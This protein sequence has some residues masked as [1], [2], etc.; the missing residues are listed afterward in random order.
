MQAAELHLLA[1]NLQPT[2]GPL[3][4]PAEQQQAAGHL[5]IGAGQRHTLACRGLTSSDLPASPACLLSCTSS[6]SSGSP[7]STAAAYLLVL[8]AACA[9][10]ASKAGAGGAARP[11]PPWTAA[12]TAACRAPGRLCH[13]LMQCTALPA[14]DGHGV[15]NIDRCWLTATA[16]ASL[17]LQLVA[18][19]LNLP[20]S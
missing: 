10:W 18:T 11:S 20:P 13:T 2:A 14:I 16:R 5:C 1:R 15:C 19:Q 9:C 6:S 7:A 12:A 8:L 3:C 17:G 4:L